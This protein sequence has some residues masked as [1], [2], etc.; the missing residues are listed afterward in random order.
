MTTFMHPQYLYF[1]RCTVIRV[2]DGDTVD[3]DLDLRFRLNLKDRFRLEG[4]D[5]P[6]LTKPTAAA[7]EASRRKLIEIIATHGVAWAETIP[8]PKTL[9]DA[10]EKFGRW[11]VQLWMAEPP[12]EGPWTVNALMVTTGYANAR[13]DWRSQWR[14]DETLSKAYRP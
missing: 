14:P 7:G 13:T 6:A 1:H 5:A 4:I 3:L 11:L 10:K 9:V 12:P 8:A 2:V